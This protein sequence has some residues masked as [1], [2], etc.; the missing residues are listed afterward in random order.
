MESSI[1]KF[2]S[3]S[4]HL[5]V[6]FLKT[7]NKARKISVQELVFTKAKDDAPPATIERGPSRDCNC[8]FVV[9]KLVMFIP[10]RQELS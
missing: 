8:R 10:K 4:D 2:E 7:K 1:G 9:R 5:H 3:R 6:T